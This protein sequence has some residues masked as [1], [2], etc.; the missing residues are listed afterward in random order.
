MQLPL[1]EKIRKSI[2]YLLPIIAAVLIIGLILSRVVDIDSTQAQPEVTISAGEAVDHIGTTAKVCGEVASADY[3]PNVSGQPTFLNLDEPYPNPVFTV[4]I[5]GEHRE[6]FRTLPEQ[7]YLN[8][9]VCVIGTIREH[10]GLPQIIVSSPEQLEL[11][12]Q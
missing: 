6:R 1:I 8:R 10:D 5:F 9:S 7:A 12:E 3:L 2:P 11:L 4:V